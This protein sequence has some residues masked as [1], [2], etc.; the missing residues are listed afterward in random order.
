MHQDDLP[1]LHLLHIVEQCFTRRVRAEVKAF[2]P[3]V[4]RYRRLAFIELYLLTG[5]RMADL[6]TY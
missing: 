4:D 1:R 2:H 3:A 5:L 6:E